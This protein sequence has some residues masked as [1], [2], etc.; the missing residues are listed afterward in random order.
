MLKIFTFL[1]IIMQRKRASSSSRGLILFHARAP[2]EEDPLHDV[3]EI[4]AYIFLAGISHDLATPLTAIKGYASGILDG[5]AFS[6]V[7][8]L[9]HLLVHVL[10]AGKILKIWQSPPNHAMIRLKGDIS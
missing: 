4:L 2:K 1:S 3:W 6:K 5:I 8:T 10:S 9:A 7:D